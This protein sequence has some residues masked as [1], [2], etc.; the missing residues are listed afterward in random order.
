VFQG[1]VSTRK[2]GSIEEAAQTAFELAPPGG[3]VVLAPACASWDMFRDYRERGDR[4]AAA[5]ARIEAEFAS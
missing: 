5:A 1:R 2:A 4:F 3:S